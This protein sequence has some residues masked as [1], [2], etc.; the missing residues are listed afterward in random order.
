MVAKLAK[1]S[2][3]N[4]RQ[5][6]GEH[7]T[8]FPRYRPAIF[9][10]R[11]LRSDFVA[12]YHREGNDKTAFVT[13]AVLTPNTRMKNSYPLSLDT[14][15]RT[16]VEIERD[17]FHTYIYI[18]I[19]YH[20]LKLT[21]VVGRRKGRREKEKTRWE[22]RTKKLARDSSTRS[23]RDW[24]FLW[25]KQREKERKEIEDWKQSWREEKRRITVSRDGNSGNRPTKGKMKRYGGDSDK[26]Q[27]TEKIGASVA[28]H[29]RT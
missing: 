15:E 25:K 6:C 5:E 1:I 22:K 23:D 20:S 27:V 21:I 7:E 12:F 24:F 18:Y 10:T 17:W 11:F 14:F 19:F 3:S 13:A 28:P 26:K 16:S 9:H 8:P 2:F 29:G 4:G